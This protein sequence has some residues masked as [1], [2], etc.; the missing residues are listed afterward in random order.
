MTKLECYL[1]KITNNQLENTIFN[2]HIEFDYDDDDEDIFHIDLDFLLNNVYDIQIIEPKQKRL[3]QYEF[4]Q[5]VLEMYENKCII[6]KNNCTAELEACHIVPVSVEENY[7]L[8]NSLLLE[9]NIHST[10]D[11]YLWSINPDTFMIE[12]GNNCGTIE[13]YKG[14]KIKLNNNLKYNLLQHYNLFLNN[15]INYTC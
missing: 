14:M 13:K 5:K 8:N 6:S 10:F 4:R 15:K 7:S 9:R 2:K 11:K 12:V 3:G 1:D